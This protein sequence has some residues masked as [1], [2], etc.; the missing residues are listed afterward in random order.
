[1]KKSTYVPEDTKN[2]FCDEPNPSKAK[3]ACTSQKVKPRNGNSLPNCGTNKPY[4]CDDKPNLE[5][6][7]STNE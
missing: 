7:G 3:D 5:A 6:T 2:Q 4:P 1:M